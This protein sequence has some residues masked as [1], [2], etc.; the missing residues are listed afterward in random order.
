MARMNYTAALNSALREELTRDERVFIMGEDVRD[1][2]MGVTKG[3]VDEFGRERIRNTPISE[4][5]VLGAGLGASA[6]GMRPVVDLM[7]SNF[8]YVAMDQIVNQAAKLR[9]MMGGSSS[10]PLTI[11]MSTGVSGGAAAQHSDS[12]HPYVMNSGGVKIVLPSN[13]YDAKGLLKAA[14]RDPDPVV[15]LFHNALGGDR[16]EVP[17]DDY[18][19]PIGF[20][21]VLREG[22]DVTIAACGL[23][24][25][26][27]LRAA[28]KLAADGIEAEVVDPRTLH[29]LGIDV[30]IESVRKTGRLVSVDEARRTCSAGS[31]ITARVAEEAW[32]SMRAAPV[33]LAVPDVPIP[34]SPVLEDEVV[35]SVE[36]IAAAARTVVASSSRS[37][38]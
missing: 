22:S 30:A 35:P 25:K 4:N 23:M 18:T 19:V 27:A 16:G 15:V 5:T 2:I 20:G 9:Y 38:A 21:R 6:A 26:R 37:L 3:L 10:F 36:R 33:T 24:A 32:D 11:L 1:A 12:V 31:E 34:F 29:P 17:D 28:D 7:M 14:I 8:I 13:P